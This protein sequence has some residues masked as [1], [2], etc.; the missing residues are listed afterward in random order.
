M[1]LLHSVS[2]DFLLHYRL[3]TQFCQRLASLRIQTAD[4]GSRN[5]SSYLVSL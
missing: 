4:V 3:C 1:G 5:A 2:Q